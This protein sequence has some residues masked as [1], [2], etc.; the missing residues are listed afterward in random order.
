M[1]FDHQTTWVL[2]ADTNTCRIYKSTT[3]PYDLKLIKELQHPQSKL[4]DIEL[5]SEKPGRYNTATTTRGTYTQQSDPKEIEI[6]NFARTIAE[7][8]D[9]SR[10]AHEYDKLIV[11][12]GPH[13]NGLL[14]HHLNKHVHHLV[15]HNLK[16]DVI[17]LTEKELSDFLRKNLLA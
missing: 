3:T 17:H 7:E 2:A 16:N 6:D 5:T 12:T 13:M 14:F 9:H 11:I 1:K 8:L 4:R 15:T 10:N